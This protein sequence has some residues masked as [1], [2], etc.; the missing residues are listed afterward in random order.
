MELIEVEL[1]EF[2]RRSRSMV[3]A[4]GD[5]LLGRGLELGEQVLVLSEEEYR[6]AVVAD[7]DFSLTETHYRLELGRVLPSELAERRVAAEVPVALG[8]LSVE[9]VADLLA[10]SSAAYRA[11]MRRRPARRLLLDG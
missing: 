8:D 11:P 2:S 10:R 5:T 6:T 3:V 9:D 1:G 4:H 7:I